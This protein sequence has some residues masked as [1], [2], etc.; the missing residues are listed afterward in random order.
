M[1]TLFGDNVKDEEGDITDKVI[2]LYFQHH[3]RLL[4]RVVLPTV[5][6][7]LQAAVAGMESSEEAEAR[8]KAA[9][10]AECVWT[11]LA[12]FLTFVRR[13]DTQALQFIAQ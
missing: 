3:T 4:T 7:P 2:H 12:E 8:W 5:Y 9:A 13:L 6:R 10:P 11:S 1:G